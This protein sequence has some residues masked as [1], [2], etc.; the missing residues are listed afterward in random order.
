MN[1]RVIFLI[2]KREMGFGY[3][4]IFVHATDLY[5]QYM[6]LLKKLQ[7]LNYCHFK[8]MQKQIQNIKRPYAQLIMKVD[9]PFN[10]LGVTIL[11][12]LNRS[13]KNPEHLDLI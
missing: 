6:H 3:R 1:F 5:L 4:Y 12:H 13:T 2:K 8:I 9:K 11:N 7:V 10:H